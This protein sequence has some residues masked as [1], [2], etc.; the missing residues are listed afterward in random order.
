MKKIKPQYSGNR[1]RKLWDKINSM[2]G[3]RYHNLH[4]A[5]VLLQ[6]MES[7]CLT[8]L[9]NELDTLLK[10]RG[11]NEKERHEEPVK[12]DRQTI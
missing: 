6:N 3:Y 9:N 8:W 2:R 4:T 12:E 10:K 7:T 1:S 5:F 11:K